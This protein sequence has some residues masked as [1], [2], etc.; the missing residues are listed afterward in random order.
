MDLPAGRYNL[1][2]ISRDSRRKGRRSN[3]VVTGGGTNF[4]DI[5]LNGTA[6]V[7]GRV[8]TSAGERGVAN[9]LVAGGD[10]LV[11]TDANGFFTVS[12]VPIG[13]ATLNAGVERSEE[14]H[15]PNS[16]PA[17]DFPRFGSAS[18]E[19]LPGEDNFVAIQLA[20]AA[21]IT[22][23]VFNA[24]GTPKGGAM[25]CHPTDEGFEFIYADADR[26]T[27]PDLGAERVAADQRRERPDGRRC[28]GR[29]RGGLGEGAGGVPGDQRSVPQRARGQLQ[30]E[31]PR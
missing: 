4:A 9:A 20:P 31:F 5:S 25:I 18:L 2:A 7:R 12:G 15:E 1:A 3:L 27:F 14:G 22:G 24:D 8:L 26:E 30:R 21:R 13:R 6:V 29:S 23:R 17:F 19:V 16:D 10:V 11:R 28:P